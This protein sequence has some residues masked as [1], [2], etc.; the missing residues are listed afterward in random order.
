[1]PPGQKVVSTGPWVNAEETIRPTDDQ[2]RHFAGFVEN[3]RQRRQ[4]SATVETLHFATAVGHLMNL[5]WEVGRSIRWDGE[6]SRVAGDEA[7]N[8]LVFRPYRAPWK[9]EV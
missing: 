8:K 2:S 7:A 4:P 6:H 1:M 5:S 3:L 9:L